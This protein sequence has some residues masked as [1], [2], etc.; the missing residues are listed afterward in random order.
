MKGLDPTNR[1]LEQGE[2]LVRAIESLETKG[3][4]Q[5]TADG[6]LTS[7]RDTGV[8]AAIALC[9]AALGDVDSESSAVNRG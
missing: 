1:I 8:T 9:G 4:T 6:T 2:A 5:V 7:V 3:P